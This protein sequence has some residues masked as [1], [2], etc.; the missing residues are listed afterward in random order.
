M[1]LPPIVLSV[2][3]WLLVPAAVALVVYGLRE[4]LERSLARNY[5]LY[6]R[7]VGHIRDRFYLDT[8]TERLALLMVASG[9]GLG[10][11]VGLLTRAPLDGV[12]AAVIG[13][14]LPTLVVRAMWSQRMNAIR[15][16][17]DTALTLMASRWRT[18]SDV[19]R[20]FEAVVEHLEPPLSQEAELV[21]R[22]LRVGTPIDEALEGLEERVPIRPVQLTCVGI[23][24]ALPLGGNVAEVLDQIGDAVR[25]SNRLEMFVDSKTTEG[26]TQAFVMGAMPFAAGYGLYR[27]DPGI[28]EPLLQQTMGNIILG[29]ALVMDLLGLFLILKITDIKV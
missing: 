20:S 15:Q 22:E 28:I 5:A 25:E 27:I 9:L 12:F 3:V 11:V 16:Q 18:S 26:R 14:A 2:L 19:G 1:T 21:V 17:I 4:R 7:W 10:V 29:A 23:R 6:L 24:Q 13:L 8:P